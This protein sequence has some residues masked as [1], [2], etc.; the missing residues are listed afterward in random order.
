[1]L[2]NL[3]EVA[4]VSCLKECCYAQ[5]YTLKYTYYV[6]VYKTKITISTKKSPVPTK[7]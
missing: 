4:S 3:S 7:Y 2:D 1:M 5:I 6:L